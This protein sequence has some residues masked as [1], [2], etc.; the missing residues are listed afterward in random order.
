MPRRRQIS[1]RLVTEIQV[2]SR[3]ADCKRGSPSK[4]V[5]WSEKRQPDSNNCLGSNPW[6]TS[7]TGIKRHCPSMLKFSIHSKSA[8]ASRECP[9]VCGKVRKSWPDRNEWWHWIGTW[10]LN[11]LSLILRVCFFGW[12][13]GNASPCH[14]WLPFPVNTQQLHTF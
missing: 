10:K 7:R 3:T 1:F 4:F 8:P 13:L 11:Y 2:P 6:T 12:S 9:A 14:Q 5:T